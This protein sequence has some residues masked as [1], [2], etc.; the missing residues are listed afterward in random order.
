MLWLYWTPCRQ[1]TDWVVPA[2]PR[3]TNRS[4]RYSVETAQARWETFD[5]RGSSRSNANRIAW[6]HRPPAVRDPAASDRSVPA[7]VAQ[8]APPPPVTRVP[9]PWMAPAAVIAPVTPRRR[10]PENA[11][12][13]VR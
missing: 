11:G 13:R 4:L 8:T 10:N 12:W 1:A 9:L 5:G 6:P 7:P 2:A 3:V